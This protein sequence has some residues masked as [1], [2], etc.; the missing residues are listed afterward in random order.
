MA[1]T[2]STDLL[3]LL[4]N[5]GN[6]ERLTS[7]PGL[8][9]VIVAL[10]RAGLI[11]LVVSQAAPATGQATTVWFRPNV[12][13]WAAE[14]V[15]FLWNGTTYV[16]ATPALWN[17]VISASGAAALNY[18]T[19]TAFGT[20][21][22][23]AQPADDVILLKAGIGAP[24]TINVNWAARTKKLTVVDSGMGALANNISVTPSVGQT[25]MSVLNYT[26]PIDSNGG[27]ITLTPLPDG[28]GA[29]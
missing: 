22:Y 23:A 16:L 3:A 26:Y 9:Y 28:S 1:Y 11:N 29:Y 4:R 24:F 13:S 5:T 18:V 6:G 12:P 17:Q 10:A 8:D 20:G 21:A 15:V 25:Q 2:T 19:I 27:S 14:G 7:M